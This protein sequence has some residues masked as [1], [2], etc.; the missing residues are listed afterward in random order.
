MVE[1]QFT[2]YNKQMVLRFAS[3][4][5]TLPQ[6][7]IV[8]PP[9]PYLQALRRIVGGGKKEM[10]AARSEAEEASQEEDEETK[11]G[12]PNEESG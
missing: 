9:R 2:A 8:A 11:R 7:T 6:N 3:G 4:S 10:K 5:A 12:A 1:C